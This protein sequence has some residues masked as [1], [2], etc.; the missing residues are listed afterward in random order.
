MDFSAKVLIRSHLPGLEISPHS[1]R[2]LKRGDISP[3]DRALS[4]PESI[5]GVQTECHVHY[6][7]AYFPKIDEDRLVSLDRTQAIVPDRLVSRFHSA[8]TPAVNDA[9]HRVFSFTQIQ[10]EMGYN[11]ITCEQAALMVHKGRNDL[12]NLEAKVAEREAK[13]EEIKV[14]PLPDGRGNR[15]ARNE[16]RAKIQVLET[17][18]EELDSE[19]E[20]LQTLIPDVA[21]TTFDHILDVENW[22]EVLK[23]VEDPL[24]IVDVCRR[25]GYLN[26]SNPCNMEHVP[27]Y[28]RLLDF[29]EWIMFRVIA[30]LYFTEEI[31]RPTIPSFDPK[32][33]RYISPSAHSNIEYDEL[34]DVDFCP[35]WSGPIKKWN[36]VEG[37]RVPKEG[38]VI[39]I[40]DK[41][42][43][44]SEK[45]AE[46]GGHKRDM[47]TRELFRLMLFKCG[48]PRPTK[49]L[50]DMEKDWHIRGEIRRPS[51]D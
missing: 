48:L 40:A 4:A 47:E 42:R 26:C 7:D 20:K 44:F 23:A 13:V 11:M 25:L 39:V 46:K 36:E 5:P 49:T 21:V 12:V 41:W 34:W 50:R 3:L 37:G 28:L 33:S 10:F 32:T 43:R 6:I 45:E 8:E 9:M 18:I 24:T 27:F 16:R 31:L 19:V 35:G 38:E 2:V 17:E 51:F 15:E 30:K 14:Q 29:E 22:K 1:I